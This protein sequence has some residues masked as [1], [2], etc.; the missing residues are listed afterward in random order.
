M[1]YEF[2]DT[3]FQDSSTNR[4]IDLIRAALTNNFTTV[5]FPKDQFT[6]TSTNRLL[7]EVLQALGQAPVGGGGGT[8]ELDRYIH[9][10][11]ATPGAPIV[12]PTYSIPARSLVKW[13]IGYSEV[14][15]YASVG[16]APGLDDIIPEGTFFPA[17]VPI[18]IDSG[19]GWCD[20][21]TPIRGNNVTAFLELVVIYVPVSIGGVIV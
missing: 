20:V 14:D 21:D 19:G 6:D 2:D 3:K 10:I 17:G 7:W 18:K 4:L 11:L 5:A 1:P 12:P 9:T 16:S 13:I 15:Q 8:S